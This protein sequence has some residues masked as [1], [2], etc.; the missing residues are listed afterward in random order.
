MAILLLV[1]T[2]HAGKSAKKRVSIKHAL[3][4]LDKNAKPHDLIDDGPISVS[5]PQDIDEGKSGEAR[6][7]RR[8][9]KMKDRGSWVPTIGVVVL[10]A[11]VLTMVFVVRWEGIKKQNTLE[12]VQME[13]NGV[14]DSSAESGNPFASTGGDASALPPDVAKSQQ[15]AREKVAKE[16]GAADLGQGFGAAILLAGIYLLTQAAGF[17]FSFEHAFVGEGKRAFDLTMGEPDYQSYHSKYIHPYESRADA[18]LAELRR[19]FGSVIPGY[20]HNPSSMTF[21]R[22]V[23]DRQSEIEVMPDAT[24]YVPPDPSTARIVAQVPASVVQTQ[25]IPSVDYD[26]AA[27]SIMILPEMDRG[28]AIGNWL[29]MNGVEHKDSLKAALASF[30]ERKAAMSMVDDEFLS[31]AKD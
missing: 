20:G 10:L 26:A 17:W 29:K 4:T 28:A 9:V 30:K 31:L 2:H 27:E 15:Q 5:S 14:S 8:V 18:R 1:L 23:H 21:R 13:K 6:F 25:S 3:G 19:H 22:Y 12:V 11:L 24:N 16:V 7:F